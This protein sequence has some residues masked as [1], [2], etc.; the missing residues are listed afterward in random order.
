[1]VP[2]TADEFVDL[3][4]RLSDLGAIRVRA[5]DFEVNLHPMAIA[6]QVATPRKVAPVQ[7]IRSKKP[8]TPEQER[9]K[10]YAEE[11]GES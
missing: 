5:G 9:L 2:M 6:N 3:V 8:M 11:L 7:E 10:L 1:M 4:K